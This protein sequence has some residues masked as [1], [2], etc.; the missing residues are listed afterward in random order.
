MAKRYLHIGFAWHGAPKTDEIQ[1]LIDIPGN[2]ETWMKYGG[3][4]WIVY[5]VHDQDAWANYLINHI[6]KQDSVIIVEI[7]NL[8][9]SNGQLPISMWEWF[10][11]PRS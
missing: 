11:E 4:C 10:N 5:T 8:P 1:K 2:V 3:N 9:H 7:T 6:S